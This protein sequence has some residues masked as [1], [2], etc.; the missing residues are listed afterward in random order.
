V[1]E[2][3]G[4]YL[5]LHR[6]R[7]LFDV[8]AEGFDVRAVVDL[9]EA[10]VDLIAVLLDSRAVRPVFHHHELLED[11]GQLMV[12]VGNAVSDEAFI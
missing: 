3:E 6:N 1:R 10:F 9:V 7:A 12:G 4:M 8:L 11:L 5:M 2:I